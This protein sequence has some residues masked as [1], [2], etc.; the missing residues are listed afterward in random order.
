MGFAMPKAET[1]QKTLLTRSEVETRLNVS[2]SFLKAALKRGEFPVPIRL[3]PQAH[4]WR[5][6]DIERVEREGIPETS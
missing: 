5:V 4:R 3:G 1:I 6:E 2:R